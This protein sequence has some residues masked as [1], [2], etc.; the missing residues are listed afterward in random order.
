ML[1]LPLSIDTMEEYPHK[2]ES[3]ERGRGIKITAGCET[4]I[5][6]K[7]IKDGTYNLKKD[8]I[9]THKYKSVTE[10]FMRLGGGGGPPDDED[11]E[12]LKF[13]MIN[14]I[15]KCEIV[16]TN[17]TPKNKKMT[18]LFQ[19]PNGSLP[20]VKSKYIDTH[21]LQLAAY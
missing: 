21:D 19:A 12:D 14:Q 11:E 4:I 8:L 20:I 18:L 1:D 15:Y 16:V 17:I 2:F 6:K 3:D 10:S 13:F 9:I 7:E 5:V